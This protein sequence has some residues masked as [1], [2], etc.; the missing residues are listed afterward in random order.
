MV[1]VMVMLM[2]MLMMMMMMMMLMLMLMLMMKVMNPT[3]YGLKKRYST[4]IIGPEIP[5]DR[6][7][8]YFMEI[9]WEKNEDRSGKPWEWN[10]IM[11]IELDHGIQWDN[12]GM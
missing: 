4:P 11:K 1:V 8:R 10:W 7:G 3:S 12:S 5:I 6:M 2:L 9:S